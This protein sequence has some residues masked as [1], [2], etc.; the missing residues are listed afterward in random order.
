MAT[1]PQATTTISSTAGAYSGGSGYPCIIAPVGTNADASSPR[2]Y[3]SAAALLSQ[4]GYAPGVDLAAMLIEEC[5]SSPQF[6]GV[7]FVGVPIVTASVLGSQRTGSTWTGTAQITVSA[8]STGYL[9]EVDAILTVTTSGTIGTAPGPIFTLSLDGG[10]TSKSIRL[11]DATSY[12]V[13]HVG[14]VLSFTSGRTLVSGE[15]YSFRTTAPKMDNTGLTAART[16][17]AAQQKTA[18]QFLIVGDMANATEANN[19][20]TQVNAYETSNKRFVFGR[21]A[22]PDGGPCAPQAKSSGVKKIAVFSAAETLT[23]AEVGATDDTITRSVGSWITDGFAVGDVVTVS[24]SVSNNV[25]GRIKALSATV[26]TFD[27]TDLAAEGPTVALGTISV[28]GSNGLIFAEVGATGDTITRNAG[29]WIADGFAVGDTVTIAGTASNNGTTDAITALS[30]T[31][32]T[33]GSFDLTAEEIGSHNV[34]ITKTQTKAAHVSAMDAA[35]ASVDAQKRIDLAYGRG[36][37]T[38]PI[39]EAYM[40]RPSFWAAAIREMQHDLHIPTYRVSDGPCSGWSLEDAN[41]KIVEYDE[42]VDG[43]AL[44]A[45]FTC[46]TTQDNGPNGAFIALSLTREAEGSMLSRTHNMAVANKFCSIIQAE[47]TLAVGI[48]LQKNADG[49][50]TED[51]LRIIESRVNKALQVGMLQPGKEGPLASGASWVASRADN[52][53]TPGAALNGFGDLNL[54]GTVENFNTSVAVQ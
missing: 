6:G 7:L 18:R 33:L 41:G 37:K 2:V 39:L 54:N 13:P 27:T 3:T 43:G 40:R 51:S 25:T 35:F 46:F 42:R 10:R 50:A 23:F 31:V 53:S 32:M 17:L 8:A 9:E 12:T 45:R 44:A 28:V 19:V 49:T 47:T 52:L 30:A 38:S 24:G 34:T 5:R 4:H 16:A 48:V 14:I 22:L 26:L 21:V 36:R 1:R 20:V 11:K 29:S 15:T